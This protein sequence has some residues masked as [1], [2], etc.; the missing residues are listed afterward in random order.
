MADFLE[1]K[2]YLLSRPCSV[3]MSNAL[4]SFL[5]PVLIQEGMKVRAH[6]IE[7]VSDT[8]IVAARRGRRN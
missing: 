5:G 8:L 2:L 6:L 4:A 3:T 1:L 7:C